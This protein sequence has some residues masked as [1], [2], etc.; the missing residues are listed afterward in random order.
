MKPCAPAASALAR[1]ALAGKLE[2]STTKVPRVARVRLSTSA[3]ESPVMLGM[4]TS[5]RTRSGRSCNT[6]VTAPLARSRV[7][8]RN[9]AC[10]SVARV[11][12]STTALSSMTRIVRE[13]L[14]PIFI[15]MAP[16]AHAFT[17]DQ[18]G[19]FQPN[20]MAGGTIAG[21]RH[22]CK[23]HKRP[24]SSTNSAPVPPA[25]RLT[26]SHFAARI[27]TM[28][29]VTWFLC[30]ASLSACAPQAALPAQPP[31]TE[32]PAPPSAWKQVEPG[33]QKQALVPEPVGVPA[34]D[35]ACQQ[36]L[37]PPRTGCERPTSELDALAQAMASQEPHERDRQLTCLEAGSAFAPGAIR[38]LR[39]ELIPE[40][41]DV[42]ALPLLE[43]R[44]ADLA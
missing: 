44:R 33:R 26:Q 41:A 13:L 17:V 15:S 19:H 23:P 22:A 31:V 32:R 40:C 14:C 12:S 27:P 20:L 1:N 21:R 16:R 24:F 7:I 42:L 39:A 8:T 30:A 38:A 4:F 6:A 37:E 36:L 43:P 34:A 11:I 28:R 3:R 2:Y 10:S 9:P 35:V 5:S 29:C 18:S 25:S